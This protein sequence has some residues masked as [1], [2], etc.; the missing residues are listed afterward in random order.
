M[1]SFTWLEQLVVQ[2]FEA[3]RS[4]W[5]SSSC[6]SYLQLLLVLLLLLL[7]LLLR[8]FSFMLG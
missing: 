8:A 5:W 1:L 4:I 7:L 2:Q 6:G 3:A